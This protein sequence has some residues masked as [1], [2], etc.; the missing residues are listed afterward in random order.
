[1][2]N[3]LTLVETRE[4]NQKMKAFKKSSLVITLSTLY[5]CK[6]SFNNFNIVACLVS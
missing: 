5:F 3:L 6:K 4:E 1:M 2:K